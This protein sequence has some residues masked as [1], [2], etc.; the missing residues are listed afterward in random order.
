M[1]SRERSALRGGLLLLALLSLSV[2]S[3]CTS[4]L[5]TAYLKG[6]PWNLS[7]PN[8]DD[9]EAD[10]PAGA[11]A[12]SSAEA[13]AAQALSPE[14]RAAAREV[15][16]E[17]AIDSLA[18]VGTVDAETESA[19]IALLQG[20]D[21]EDWPAVVDEFVAAL[22]AT[23]HI[24]AKPAAA[25]VTLPA[26]TGP[27][28][29]SV[30]PL[31]PVTPPPTAPEPP[32]PTPTLDPAANAGSAGDAAPADAGSDVIE[33]TAAA[34]G[35]RVGVGVGGADLGSLP[36]TRVHEPAGSS[37]EEEVAEVS[38]HNACF[39]TRVQAWGVVDRFAVDRFRPGQEVIVYFELENLSVDRTPGGH[40]T[41]IDTG[42]VLVAADGR[43]LH[44]WSFE[45]IQ[46][47]CPARRRDYFARYVVRIPGSIPVGPCR[48]EI[49]VTDTLA[50]RTA[51]TTVPLEIAT[52]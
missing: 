14:A 15:A 39:A 49:A 42:L 43:R 21:Q 37:A 40:T 41:C 48:L 18:A 10:E 50:G 17:R 8:A 20:T 5:T 31:P 11:A 38:V 1:V 34:V 44:D 29:A 19:L 45:P 32:D 13:A 12:E 6:T 33:A 4:A 23:P 9:G 2:S 26:A 25:V 28:A 30:E 27:T 35:V 36:Q 51:T 22:A 47:T 46:E 7:D 3:G 52:D 24:A 16:I